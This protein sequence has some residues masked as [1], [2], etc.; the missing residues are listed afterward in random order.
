MLEGAPPRDCV[1]LLA[2]F[3]AHVGNSS[4]TWRDVIGRNGLADL[5]QVV[6]CC[7]TS[8]QTSLAMTSTMFEHKFGHNCTWE[9]VGGAW[10]GHEKDFWTA[11]K[12]GSD[13][14]LVPRAKC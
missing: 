8:V 10:R 7:W 3:N 6:C 11:S 1:V 5:N 13:A 2:D 12:R 14:A 9:C 4:E